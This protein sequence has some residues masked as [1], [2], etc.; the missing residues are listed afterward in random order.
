MVE[1]GVSESLREE[2]RTQLRQI[3]SEKGVKVF[4]ACESGSRAWGFPSANSDFDVR[5]LYAHPRDWYLS[6]DLE[7]RRDVIERPISDLLDISGWDLRKALQLFR[8]S[9]PPLLEWLQSPIVYLEEGPVASWLRELIPTCYSPRASLYHYLQMAR[10]NH[11]DYLLGDVVWVKKYF[12][13]LRPLLAIKWIE[14]DLGPVP[15]EFDVL[16]ERTVESPALV[17]AI[18][19]LVAAKR[20]GEELDRGPRLAPIS[21]FIEGELARL[22]QA[23]VTVPKAETPVEALNACFRSALDELWG[24]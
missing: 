3:E 5:F 23:P 9:N 13:V 24:T 21:A 1:G 4:F 19:A 20:A 14:A 17:A 7:A 10:G 16:M 2:V 8:K 22:E 11:R 6:V 12:Y 15:M 18:G